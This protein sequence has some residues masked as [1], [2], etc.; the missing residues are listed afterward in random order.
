LGDGALQGIPAK[1]NNLG[2][3]GF[4]FQAISI[5]PRH[6]GQIFMIRPSYCQKQ[7]TVPAIMNIWPLRKPVPITEISPSKKNLHPP[8]LMATALPGL[9]EK[10]LQFGLFYRYS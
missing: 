10:L 8:A 5:M 7:K 2:N 3:E 1:A 9:F 4:F 6:R